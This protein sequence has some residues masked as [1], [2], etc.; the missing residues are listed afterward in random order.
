[1]IMPGKS[2][3]G[4]STL[5]AALVH[6]GWDYLCDEFALIHARSHRM[7]PYPRAVCIKK[8]SYAPLQEFGLPVGDARYYFKGSKGYVTFIN[9]N[10][11][12]RRSVGS[13]CPVRFIVFPKYRERQRP[14]LEPIS[15]AEAAFELHQH[16]FNLL[17]C[18][19]PGL[20][21]IAAFI[22]HTTCYRLTAGTLE[23]TTALLDTMASRTQQ[24][25]ANTA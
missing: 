17:N 22:R 13:P 4:K 15:R 14:C 8:P 20:D 11:I 12:R 16:C 3:S 25:L 1:M 6:K 2:G 9:P 5:T 10:R 19:K 18:E 7:H 23:E 24:A 21:I